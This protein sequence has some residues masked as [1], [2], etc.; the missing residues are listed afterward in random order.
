MAEQIG[1]GGGGGLKKEVTEALN[2]HLAP[3][4]AR[5]AELVTDPGYLLQVLHEG[6]AKANEVAEA[7]LAEVRVAMQMDY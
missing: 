1:D 5:R 4:R 7:T 6:N 3:I 2:E